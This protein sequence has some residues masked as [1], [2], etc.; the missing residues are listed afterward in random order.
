MA[1]TLPCRY[2]HVG[3]L[4]RPSRLKTARADFEHGR[5]DAEALTRIEDACIREVVAKQEAIGLRA[6]TDGEFRRSWWH[7][8]YLAGLAGVEVAESE[9]GIQFHGVQTKSQKIVV[10]GRVDFDRHYMLEHFRFLHAAAGV[11]A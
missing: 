10:N 1:L 9:Q 11:T 4:L 3:S 8:D 2:D 7:F 6:V 5:I